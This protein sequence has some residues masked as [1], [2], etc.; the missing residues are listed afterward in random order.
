M[1]YSQQ[2]LSDSEILFSDISTSNDINAVVSEGGSNEF[3]RIINFMEGKGI[4]HLNGNSYTLQEG[5]IL[6]AGSGD[7]LSLDLYGK[8]H[9]YTVSFL[10]NT[11]L[12][13]SQ[14]SPDRGNIS[15]LLYEVIQRR[16][17]FKEDF[18]NTEIYNKFNLIM[19]EWKGRS[20][21]YDL[22]IQSHL[23]FIL[24]KLYRVLCATKT[25]IPTRSSNTSIDRAM[26]YISNNLDSVS[27]QTVAEYCGLSTVYFSTLFKSVVGMNFSEYVIR[28][29]ISKAKTLLVQ[30]SASVAFIAYEVGFSSS[31]H[32][33]SKFRSIEGI[34]PAKYRSRRR[35]SSESQKR[36]NPVLNLEFNDSIKKNCQFLIIKYRTNGKSPS[37][38]VPFFINSQGL[39]PTSND[40]S[41]VRLNMDEKWHVVVINMDKTAQLVHTYTPDDKGLYS[42][43]YIKFILFHMSKLP[44]EYIDLSYVCFAE[45]IEEATYI[46]G[47]CESV[48]YGYFDHTNWIKLPFNNDNTPS[49]Y[50]R[51]SYYLDSKCLFEQAVSRGS[52]IQSVEQLNE[53]GTDFI[54]IRYS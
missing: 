23:V 52:S 12:G 11:S 14:A 44:E 21:G 19:G 7:L 29:R 3:I 18:T 39:P 43:K 50:S 28:A 27:E 47:Q 35:I 15:Y 41:W 22:L 37:S 4:A 5:V 17:F 36:V 16:I 45:S 34:T 2:N 38:S 6:I 30:T 49:N 10:P 40:L 46:V 53:F 51:D 25:A 9:Y 13:N 20:P 48:S 8:T 26:M 24:V 31:S 54:R 32:F 42:A 33:I 1:S